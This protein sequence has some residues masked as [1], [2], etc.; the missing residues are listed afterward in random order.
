[1]KYITVLGLPKKGSWKLF[2]EL[3]NPDLKDLA[4]RLP[5]TVLHSRADSTV[6]KYLRA[7]APCYPSK[8]A[9]FCFIP[10]ALGRDD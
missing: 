1:M 3:E 2:D 10:S 9:P 6:T 8:A 5:D 4:S 7:E